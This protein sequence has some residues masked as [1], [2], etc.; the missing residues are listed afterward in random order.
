MRP[1]RLRGA[2]QPPPMAEVRSSQSQPSGST[3]PA[4]SADGGGR[5]QEAQSSQP[6]FSRPATSAEGGWAQVSYD[7]P[8][9][10]AFP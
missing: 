5:Q 10:A 2:P 3:R 9:A 7:P 1:G 4:A 6:M 8:D